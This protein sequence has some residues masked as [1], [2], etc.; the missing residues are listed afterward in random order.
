MIKR[1]FIFYLKPHFSLKRGQFAKYSL[2]AWVGYNL[3]KFRKTTPQVSVSSLVYST[4]G[5]GV[6]LNEK[7]SSSKSINYKPYLLFICNSQIM[8]IHSTCSINLI[9]K[10]LNKHSNINT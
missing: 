4:R 6:P 8:K 5:I 1:I 3:F 9:G 7:Q 2:Q 10:T